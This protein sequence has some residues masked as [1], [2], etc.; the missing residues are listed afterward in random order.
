LNIELK[1]E[2]KIANCQSLW[3]DFLP[4]N[5][6]LKSRH[7]EAFENAHIDDIENFYIQIFAKGK[8]L[9][10]LYLQQFQ[11]QHKYLSFNDQQQ[12]LSKIIKLLLP[13]KIPLLVC[14]HLF[15]IN[16][17]GF[18]FKNE[19]HRNLVFDAVKIFTKQIGYCKPKGII[20]KDCEDVFIEQNCTLFGYHF[21]NG[22]VTMELQRR[23]HWFSFDDYLKDL[24]KKYLQRAKK[25]I[26]ALEGI[27][28]RQLQAD[29]IIEEH[30][31]INALYWQVVNK[32]SVKLGTINAQYFSEMKKDLKDRFEFHTLYKNQIMIGFYTFIFYDANRMETHYIGL[33]YEEN[34]THQIYFNILFLAAKRMIEGQYNRLELGRTARDAKANLGAVPKQIFNYI[35]VKNI[36]CKIRSQSFSKQIQRK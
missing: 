12:A 36:F 33:D 30:E 8:L 27:E 5:H 4:E 1:I 14:G 28:K 3:D 11:F 9:G 23:P 2:Q 10:V 35:S 25:I 20:V 32:Q 21:F 34:K 18:Y 26:K 7:L 24:H 15:R 31:A 19:S 6:H 17:Q 29:E 22:D 16:F 13:N